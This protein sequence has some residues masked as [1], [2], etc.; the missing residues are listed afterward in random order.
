MPSKVIH[1]KPLVLGLNDDDW[2]IGGVCRSGFLD[3][4]DHLR[5]TLT[6][7][8]IANR[9]LVPN[10]WEVED[11]GRGVTPSGW[12]QWLISQ[13]CFFLSAIGW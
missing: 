3:W 12:L 2:S 8:T 4:K 9:L 10:S 6:S 11:V 1:L 13:Q 7:A 5:I